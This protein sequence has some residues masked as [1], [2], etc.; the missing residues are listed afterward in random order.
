[1]SQVKSNPFLEA[2]LGQIPRLLGQL[3]RNALS[4]SYGSFDRAYWHYRTNDISCARYQEAVYTLALLYC[5]DFEGNR[6]FRDKRLLEWIKASLRFTAGIQRKNGSFDEWY[7]HEGSYVATAFLTSAVSQTIAL[8][9]KNNISL[10]EEKLISDVLIKAAEF[11]VNRNEEAALNQVSGA[12]FAVANVGTLYG[13]EKFIGAA[14]RML[15]K[16]L[17]EQRDEGW[18]NEYG[19]PDIGYLSLTIN[20]LE[21]YSFLLDSSEVSNAISKAK[22]F[23]LCF[24]NPDKTA[25]GEYMSR[26]TEYLIPSLTLPYF[27]A[28]VPAH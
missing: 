9:K 11:L 12:I 15:D 6:Y 21:K 10:E 5:V 1:M 3:N 20:Y 7:I 23:V 16:F 26:N 22:S 17:S 2:V 13:K 19:G 4:R 24:I 28:L 27:G 14:N 18:W 8:F 25:G